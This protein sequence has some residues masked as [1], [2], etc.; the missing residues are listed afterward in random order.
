MNALRA[1]Y[2]A[3]LS[4]FVVLS[5][6]SLLVAQQ[7]SQNGTESGE[8]QLTKAEEEI[9]RIDQSE[10][11]A[12]LA[13]DLAAIEKLWAE[14]FTVNAP[15][16]QIARGREF[17]LNLVKN[18]QLDYSSFDRKVEAVMLYPNTAII[19]GEETVTPQR[20]APLAGQ[21]VRRRITNIW[22]KRD[23][24]WQL[25]ARQATIIDHK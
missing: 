22:M 3:S 10:A 15:N 25:T 13:N 6:G 18:G 17:I 20:K 2:L 21:T 24:N 4:L 19:M 5:I 16:N 9:R 11:A 8:S 14:D 23:G 1:T 12:V 7:P